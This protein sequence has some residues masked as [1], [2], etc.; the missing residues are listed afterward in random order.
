MLRFPP[1]D[2]DPPATQ[3]TELELEPL[4]PPPYLSRSKDSP[5][6]LSPSPQ[7]SDVQLASPKAPSPAQQLNRP[8]TSGSAV[9]N[10][11]IPKRGVRFADD[12]GKDDQ[13]PLG[14][15]LRIRKNKEQKA[16][17][18]REER[19]RRE[20]AAQPS[21]ENR[22]ATAPPQANR[23]SKVV[24]PRQLPSRPLVSLNEPP[25]PT[26]SHA[27][28]EEERLR[29]EAERIEME[30]LRRSREMARKQAEERERAYI[31][32]LQATRARRD[33]SRAGRPL[34]S[35][36]LSPRVPDCD[37]S[38]SR[39][40][41][42][43]SLR[44]SS[45]SHKY[46]PDLVFSP[47]S[48]YEGSPS[49]SV[50][51]TPGSQHSFSRPPSLYSAHT[52]S[53][54]DVRARDGKRA[55]RRM[56]VVSD[57]PKGMSL[58]P[59][60]D[61]RVSFNPYA[62]MN[63]PPVP[64]MPAIPTVNGVPFYGMDMPLLPPTAPFMMNQFGARPRSYTG[65]SGQPSP[66]QSSTS[67]SRNYS[68]EGVNSNSRGSSPRSSGSH[69]R[70]SSDDATR[71]AKTLGDSRSGSYT[72][73]RGG[74]TPGSLRVAPS[75]SSPQRSS[76]LSPEQGPT[77]KSSSLRPMSGVYSSGAPVH[78]HWRTAAS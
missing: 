51:A 55:S 61:P 12:D 65:S 46:T 33:A 29:R 5:S 39:D 11:P 45:V 24:A 34:E 32:E 28:R 17:F 52:A 13:I 60:Y 68:S 50:L 14:Y 78:A 37:R 23:V 56:S 75:Q 16:R 9:T 58:H 44:R 47:V 31:E 57:S 43:A 41:M 2:P 10:D 67:L 54:E 7:P 6:K 42:H 49:S 73:V 36:S 70:R 66:Q 19:E 25:K 8:T 72:D 30:K 53:S 26:V 3:T 4:S 27:L 74:K 18:L 63:V 59:P 64:V 38:A 48:P 62:W 21:L 40:S 22:R 76:W 77:K 35:A 1:V 71:M 20:R 15:V 69:Q